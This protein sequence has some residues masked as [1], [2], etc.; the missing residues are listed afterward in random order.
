MRGVIGALH[1][2]G[3]VALNRENYGRAVEIA[4]ESVE[5]AREVGARRFL[6]MGLDNF[7]RALLCHGDLDRAARLWIEGAQLSVEYRDRT[8]GVYYLEGLAG[9]AARWDRPEL[10]ATLAGAA[11]AT[12]QEINEPRSGPEAEIIESFLAPARAC[13]DS[14]G[15]ET[16]WAVGEGMSFEDAISYALSELSAR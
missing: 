15:W 10:A 2:L 11:L 6:V 9:V 12:R 7:A 16:A 3:E 14:T 13:L 5:L 1:L 8:Y 4:G